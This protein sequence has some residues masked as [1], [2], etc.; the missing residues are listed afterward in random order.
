MAEVLIVDDEKNILEALNYLLKDKYILTLCS[1]GLEALKILRK[2]KF[3][4]VLLDQLIGDMSGNEILRKIKERDNNT[5]VIML[6]AHKTKELVFDAGR[7]GAE[8]Y[9]LKPFDKNELLNLLESIMKRKTMNEQQSK[10]VVQE[11][12]YK[13][14][15]I[16]KDRYTD[17]EI[18]IMEQLCEGKS[19]N[20]I[21][22]I[23]KTK[24]SSIKNA[25]RVI[26]VKLK[27]KN[28]LKAVNMIR[29]F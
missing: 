9:I 3:D 18:K 6:S 27:V 21:A 1:K 26:F 23:L 17:T 24:E 15:N 4:I 5:S 8:E 19:N 29:R 7:L 14:I 28:R 16:P 12:K 25:L 2:K 22:L 10:G 20:E 11:S 13:S